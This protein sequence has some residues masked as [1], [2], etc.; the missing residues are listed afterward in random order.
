M[1]II[2]IPD[3][4]HTCRSFSEGRSGIEFKIQDWLARVLAILNL[5]F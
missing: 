3:F 5:E 2:G 1:E 4:C